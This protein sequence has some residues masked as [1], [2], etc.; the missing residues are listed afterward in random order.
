MDLLLQKQ[1]VVPFG[2]VRRLQLT[3][4]HNVSWC[5]VVI[6]FYFKFTLSTS[7][8]TDLFP[9][10]PL[11]PLIIMKECDYFVQVEISNILSDVEAADYGESVSP[12]F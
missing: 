4:K 8:P 1:P 3:T 2:K 11:F 12:F 10:F 6:L 9:L 7:V 5:N